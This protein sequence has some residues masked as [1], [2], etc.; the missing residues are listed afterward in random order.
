LIFAKEILTLKWLEGRP[1]DRRE[2]G[3]GRRFKG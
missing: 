1:E 3:K 2:R